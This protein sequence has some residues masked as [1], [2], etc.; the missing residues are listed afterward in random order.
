[1]PRQR[2]HRSGG[3]NESQEGMGGEYSTRVS[4]E[5]TVNVGLETNC[6]YII[7]YIYI[8]YLDLESYVEH[9]FNIDCEMM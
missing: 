1:M 8:E 2:I 3:E 6:L 4:T 7:K 9:S 5:M